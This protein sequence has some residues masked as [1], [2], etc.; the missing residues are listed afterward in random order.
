MD[1]VDNCDC[2]NKPI[3]REYYIKGIANRKNYFV[4]CEKCRIRTRNRK[5]KDKAIEEWNTY[6]GEKYENYESLKKSL[7]QVKLHREGK[8]KLDTWEE[9]LKKKHSKEKIMS[10]EEII[11]QIN[12]YILNLIEER[13]SG[14]A[15][16]E[17]IKFQES[18]QG[19][20]DLYNKQKEKINAYDK[21]LERYN[22]LVC[23]HLQYEEMTGIDLL[24]PDKLDVISKDKIKAKIEALKK[25]ENYKPLDNK[26]TYY[27]VIKHGEEILQEL[28]EEE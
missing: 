1:I 16:I 6:K 19:L 7:K 14:K 2:G 21:L 24:L 10:E 26:F 20:L 28:L 27:E 5:T 12:I 9:Y 25:F 3:I 4:K 17:Q 11:K 22:K 8:I 18:I 23:C 15:N 13:K